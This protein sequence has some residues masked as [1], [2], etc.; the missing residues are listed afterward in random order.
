MSHRS[1][2]AFALVISTV[3]LAL[4]PSAVHAQA[5]VFGIRGLG[6]PGRMLST[7]AVGTGGAFGLFDPESALNA[8][9][10]GYV[11]GMS[12][13]FTGLQEYRSV[14]LE[15]GDASLR[16]TRFPLASVLV[17]FKNF[18]MVL[19]MSVAGYANRDFSVVRSDTID[20]RGVP[21]GISDTVLS[22][23]GITDLRFSAAVR[24]IGPA[25]IGASL[26]VLTGRDRITVRRGFEDT[27]YIDVA[28]RSELSTTG[29]GFSVG[30]VITITPRFWASALVRND[31]TQDVERDSVDVSSD[32]PLP[33]T[34]GGG[35]RWRPTGKLDIAVQGLYRTWSEADSAL[36]AVNAPGAANT[37]DLSI[38]MEL[39]KNTRQ[40]SHLPIRLGVHYV[41]LPFLVDREHQPGQ[42]GASIGTGLRFAQQKAGIDV[43]VE[44]IWRWGGGRKENVWSIWIGGS[45]RP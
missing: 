1:R 6:L 40:P 33:W 32:L 17:P 21:V 23:G 11:A 28:Q 41:T 25:T 36:L 22:E 15:T 10:F 20:L 14:S 29:I 2:W 26:H 43:S 19:G 16:G 30:T 4:A 31:G 42:F 18:P 39:V 27:T 3:G 34:F 24:D 13:S 44:R 7:R 38:G 35:L 45:V 8:G 37:I 5:S 9:A 12:V